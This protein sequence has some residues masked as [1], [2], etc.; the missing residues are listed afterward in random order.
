MRTAECIRLLCIPNTHIRAKHSSPG[1]EVHEALEVLRVALLDLPSIP[2]ALSA[3]GCDRR[4]ASVAVNFQ[5]L[6]K[7][8]S[9][10]LH[11]N[12]LYHTYVYGSLPGIP[13]YLVISMLQN[14][15]CTSAL[16]MKYGR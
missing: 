10:P 12:K 16:M 8:E 6:R 7:L 14:E 1:R 4:R 13:K 15:A 11:T 5:N 3:T 2:K 9:K